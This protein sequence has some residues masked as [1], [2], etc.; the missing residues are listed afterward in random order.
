[1]RQNLVHLFPT[2]RYL[3]RP[4]SCLQYRTIYRHTDRPA[5][6]LISKKHAF[7][8]TMREDV[9]QGQSRYRLRRRSGVRPR[10]RRQEGL[11]RRRR[12]ERRAQRSRRRRLCRGWNTKGLECRVWRRRT[13][14]VRRKNGGDFAGCN[15]GRKGCYYET[16]RGVLWRA[17]RIPAAPALP[18]ANSCAF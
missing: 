4:F 14:C 7:V 5:D 17:R 12:V 3:L 8:S 10:Q 16:L 11:A 6:P 13:I 2:R 9:L 15:H 18:P 1:M